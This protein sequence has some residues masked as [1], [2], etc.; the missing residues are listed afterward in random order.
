MGETGGLRKGSGRASCAK[1]SER[2]QGR[3]LAQKK[4]QVLTE[5]SR[6]RAL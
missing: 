4:M 2:E 3:E 1:R 6:N 5:I